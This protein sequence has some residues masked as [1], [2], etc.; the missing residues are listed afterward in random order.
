MNKE[1]LT[2]A[3][4]QRKAE[5]AHYQVNIDNYTAMIGMLPQWTEVLLA[6]RTADP[7]GFINDWSFE[8]IQLLSDLQ[9]KDK[10]ERTLL[11][12]RLEQRK[13]TFVLKAL[14]Q[15]LEQA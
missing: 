13:A 5:I 8:D 6:H 7:V 12:E 11:T 3:I 1:Q 10:L 9:F 15:K 4:K 2:E 14:Q